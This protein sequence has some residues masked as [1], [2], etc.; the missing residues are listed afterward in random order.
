LP[1]LGHGREGMNL[2]SIGYIGKEA[3]SK[4]EEDYQDINLQEQLP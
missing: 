2:V 1:V 4:F 3:R